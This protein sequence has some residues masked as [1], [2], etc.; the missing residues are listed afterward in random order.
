M[1][2]SEEMAIQI[3]DTNGD[4]TCDGS[5]FSL[6][7]EGGERLMRALGFLLALWAAAGVSVFIPLAHFV[8]VPGFLLAGLFFAVNVYRTTEAMDK[9]TGVCPACNKNICIGLDAKDTLPKFC[10]CPQCNHSIQLSQG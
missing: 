4:K 3:R 10:Y 5:L 8:L 2:R 9:V 6:H 1:P 7:Y